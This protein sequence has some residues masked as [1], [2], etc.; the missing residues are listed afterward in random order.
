MFEK[1][2]NKKNVSRLY[3]VN[4]GLLSAL[5]LS[6][7]GSLIIANFGTTQRY[8]MAQWLKEYATL[9]DEHEKLSLQALELQSTRRLDAES[10]RL[11]L[12]KA[13]AVVYLTAKD[14][15]ALK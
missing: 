15:V 8:E 14:T 10:S 12:V 11:Q 7:M 1:N 5:V 4:I 13:D 3:R 2:K 9:Q 6:Y